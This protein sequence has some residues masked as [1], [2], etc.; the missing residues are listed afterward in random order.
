MAMTATI[1][2]S[3]S[4][5]V[6]E[7]KCTAILVVSNS[8]AY[9]VNLTGV[10]GN[11]LITGGTAPTYNS[12]VSI[13]VVNFGP[14]AVV[15]VPA[16]GSLTLT[17]D[18]KFHGPSTGYLSTGANTYS[19]SALCYSDDGSVFAPTAATVTVNYAVTY[20]ASQS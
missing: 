10:I 16:S 18:L 12:G 1:T 2:T 4:T 14:N 6:T 8:S 19:V 7:Q 20:N 5:V 3:P 11:S 13:G 17:F 9:P 15:T